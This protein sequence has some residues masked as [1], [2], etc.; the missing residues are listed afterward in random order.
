MTFNVGDIVRHKKTKRIFEL[1]DVN[2]NP[3]YAADDEYYASGW[4]DMWGTETASTPDDIE[5]VMT[6]ADAANRKPPTVDEIAESLPLT[7]GF[8]DI[9][10]IDETIPLGDGGVECLAS[11]EDGLRISFVVTVSAVEVE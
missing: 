3:N 2:P 10:D 7:R 4:S 8:G 11:T 6:A 9:I 5:L 1:D